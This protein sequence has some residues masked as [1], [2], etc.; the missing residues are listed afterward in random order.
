MNRIAD[1][2]GFGFFLH[3]YDQITSYMF[4]GMKP[5]VLSRRSFNELFEP[6]FQEKYP[7]RGFGYYSVL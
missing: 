4:N 2:Y 5:D 1:K 6:S 7:G 3:C